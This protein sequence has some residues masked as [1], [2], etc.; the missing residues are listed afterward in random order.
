MGI[1]A[2]RCWCGDADVLAGARE[3]FAV[4]ACEIVTGKLFTVIRT[5]QGFQ[6]LVREERLTKVSSAFAAGRASIERQ[7]ARPVTLSRRAWPDGGVMHNGGN[8]GTL[9]VKPVQVCGRLLGVLMRFAAGDAVS[10]LRY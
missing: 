8:M 9:E 1:R 2:N 4:S 3:R 10:S 7:L 6:E 5:R